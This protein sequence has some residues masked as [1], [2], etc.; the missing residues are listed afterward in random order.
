MPKSGKTPPVSTVTPEICTVPQRVLSYI[1]EISV[2][3]II[4]NPEQPRKT[5]LQEEI[6]E[7]AASIKECG[8]VNAI[9]VYGPFLTDEIGAAI[10]NPYYVLID[11]ERRLKSTQ[12]LGLL[13]IRAEVRSP[14]PEDMQSD[15]QL[16]LATVANLQRS[17]LTPCEEAQAYDRLISLKY[18]KIK[19]SIQL[20][21]SVNHISNRLKLLA[22]DP[23]IQELIDSKLLPMDH[24][25]VDALLSIDDHSLRIKLAKE[26]SS[27]KAGI[28]SCLTAVNKLTEHRSG[29]IIKQDEIPAVKLASRKEGQLSRS[30]YDVIAAVGT[31]PPWEKVE[32][33]ARI[34]CDFCGLRS[35]ASAI[36]CKGCPLVEFVLRLLKV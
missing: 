13:T 10:P 9:Q 11:G 22:L 6:E 29:Q 14:K 3:A 1:A 2:D 27:I 25:V 19:I 26:L 12:L 20:G 7:L 36:S 4:P 32:A 15:R 18:S 30:D 5:F 31:V 8:L 23:P 33:S 28:P 24:K 34:T 35:S 21:K 17:D 16:I